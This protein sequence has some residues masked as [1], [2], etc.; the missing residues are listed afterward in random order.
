ML[1]GEGKEMKLN[2][3]WKENKAQYQTG[4]SLYLNRIRLGSYG[5]NA[6]RSK[7][8]S[9]RDN[10]KDWAG[11]I[12]LPSLSDTVKRVYGSSTEEVKVKIEEIVTNWLIEAMK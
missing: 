4:E 10:L 1:K 11:D 7:S 9:E 8:E 12:A 5:W 3:Q 6:S 2:F